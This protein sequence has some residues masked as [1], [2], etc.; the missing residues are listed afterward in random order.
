MEIRLFLEI[1][2]QPPFTGW[3]GLSALWPQRNGY[4][5]AGAPGWYEAAPL[6]LAE[7]AGPGSGNGFAR[8]GL[9]I[10]EFPE[11]QAFGLGYNMRGFQPNGRRRRG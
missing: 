4:P 7:T 9:E 8:A 5:G 3:S 6:A 2:P 11:N 1:Q 10:W